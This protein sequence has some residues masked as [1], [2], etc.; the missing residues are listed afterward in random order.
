M[1]KA[2]RKYC[3]KYF[4]KDNKL[5]CNKL[6]KIKN[7]NNKCDNIKVVFY[8]TKVTELNELLYKYKAGSFHSNY[9]E[10]KN[11]FYKNKVGYIGPNC[12]V[13]RHNSMQYK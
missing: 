10:L 8:V 3:K 4:I 13:G 11:E 7:Q 6:I 5:F 2:F 12:S 9:K 1:K